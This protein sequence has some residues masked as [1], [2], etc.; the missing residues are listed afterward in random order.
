M[1]LSFILENTLK[2]DFFTSFIYV[3]VHMFTCHG[4]K[5]NK[6]HEVTVKKV[7]VCCCG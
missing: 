4:D 1:F 7:S 3:Y 2:Y 5:G 6:E